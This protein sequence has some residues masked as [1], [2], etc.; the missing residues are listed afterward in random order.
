ML[1]EIEGYINFVD[2]SASHLGFPLPSN[3]RPTSHHR[4]TPYL[5]EEKTLSFNKIEHP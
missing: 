2:I 5:Q 1:R 4:N 3:K